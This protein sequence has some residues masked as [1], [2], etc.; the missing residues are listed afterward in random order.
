MTDREASTAEFGR[1][2]GVLLGGG[3]EMRRGLRR[4][5]YTLDEG[6]IW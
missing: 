2:M 4:R 6:R 3:G 5:G 1:E